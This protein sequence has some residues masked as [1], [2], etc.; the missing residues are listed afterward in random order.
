MPQR[1]QRKRE[2]GWRMPDGAV[3]VGRG[4]KWGNPFAYRTPYALMREPA[5]HEPG[6]PAEYEGR[7][8]SDGQYHPYC[9]PGGKIIPCTVRYMTL[10]ECVEHYRMAI[11]GPS[12]SMLAAH[13]S[14]KKH[15]GWLTYRVYEGPKRLGI[16]TIRAVTAADV[17]RE[18]AGKDLACWCPLGQPCHA[19]ALLELANREEP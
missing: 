2:K 15:G 1:I 11:V 5:V 14:A 6:K 19:D 8:S 3:Y 13:P 9:L 7:I 16:W 4:T 12:A 17:R 18:L 10:A